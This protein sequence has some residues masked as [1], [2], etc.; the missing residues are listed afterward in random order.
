MVFGCW[1]QNVSAGGE[2]RGARAR[3]CTLRVRAPSGRSSEVGTRRGTS[4]VKWTTMNDCQAVWTDEGILSISVA[5]ESTRYQACPCL[6]FFGGF[7]I[8]A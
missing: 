7:Q 8:S 5:S 6:P 1:S 3:I 2:S 4:V